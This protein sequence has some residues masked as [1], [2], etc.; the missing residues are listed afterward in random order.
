MR[1]EHEQVEYDD[2]AWEQRLHQEIASAG[3]ML[4]DLVQ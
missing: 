1:Y 4:I 2:D 3:D